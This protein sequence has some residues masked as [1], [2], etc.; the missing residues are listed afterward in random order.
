[1]D[2]FKPD[3]ILEDRVETRIAELEARL[4][5]AESRADE[6]ELSADLAWE[7][8]FRDRA[9]VRQFG[10]R[11]IRL[12]ALDE[13]TTRTSPH[14]SRILA[15]SAIAHVELYEGKIDSAISRCLEAKLALTDRHSS[16][17][18][19]VEHV[20]G[21]CHYFLGNY[22][23][24]LECALQS[25]AIARDFKNDSLLAWSL[26][27]VASFLALNGNT[28]RSF[29]FH[30]EASGFFLSLGDAVGQMCS[31]NYYVACLLDSGR[32]AQALE[33]KH[34]AA[35]QELRNKLLGAEVSTDALTWSPKSA[36]FG[37][38]PLP[39]IFAPLAF[40]SPS[41][42]PQDRHRLVQ[43][44]QRCLWPSAGRRMSEKGRLRHR[45]CSEAAN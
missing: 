37:G 7:L 10:E 33:W 3:L 35:D 11:A 8:R 45:P 13:P 5:A 28:D 34:E 16:V 24:A 29:Q 15:S 30:E 41:G 22:P 2:A 20:L 40:G 43:G 39:R 31:L 1:M 26:D 25:L 6:C 4:A 36:L 42:R 32:P 17:A 18:A 14:R 19:N 9:K 27:E 23:E 38:D 44:L 21:W 12:A